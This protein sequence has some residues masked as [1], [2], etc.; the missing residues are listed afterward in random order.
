MQDQE[1]N[2]VGPQIESTGYL[3]K[4]VVQLPASDRSHR[5]NPSSA[6]IIYCYI[7]YLLFIDNG[8]VLSPGLIFGCRNQALAIFFW[9]SRRIKF[10]ITG[11]LKTQSRAVYWTV[12]DM[13]MR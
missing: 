3:T 8:T 12:S 2:L 10:R 1:L 11:I 4:H 13:L 5:T 6:G 9:I 7:C